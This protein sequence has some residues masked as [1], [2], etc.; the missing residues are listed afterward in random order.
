MVGHQNYAR[1]IQHLALAS[2]RQGEGDLGTQIDGKILQREDEIG[3]LAQQLQASGIKIQNLL[4]K[5]QEFLRDVSHEVRAPLARLQVSAETLELDTNDRRALNQIKQEVQV[6]DQL[7]QDLL[8]LAHFDRPSQIHKIENIPLPILI[9]LCV[10]RSQMLASRKNVLIISQR[11]RPTR[12]SVTGV[13]F[14]LDRALDNL[15]NNA[16]RHSPEYGEI[17]VSCEIGKENCCLRIWD[18][19][20]GV[21]EDSLEEIFEPFVRWIHHGTDKPEDW[22]WSLFG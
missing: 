20:D 9:D 5:Q 6:I 17:T 21:A 12:P 15:M 16:I 2:D 19:G 11:Y 10:E 14:L 13:Q 7:V 1:P 22:T 8:H 4:K 18:Q 3:G